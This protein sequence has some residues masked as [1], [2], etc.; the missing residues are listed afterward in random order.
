VD[1]R[2]ALFAVLVSV[3]AA[4]IFGLAPAVHAAR[5]NLNDTLKGMRTTGRVPS[6]LR[7]AFV[8]VQLSLALMLLFGAGLLARGFAR[9]LDWRPGF[10]RTNLATAWMSP[11]ANG[12]RNA[13]AEMER[14]RDEVAA[15]PGI[16][17]AALCSAGPLFGGEETGGLAIEGRPAFAPQDMPTVQ[18]F[19]VGPHYFETLGVR[20]LRGRGFSKS[21]AAGAPHVG[22]INQSLARRFFPGENP[23]GRQV[24]VNDHPS[25]IV[26]V[27]ADVRPLQ[28]D[29]PTP[30]QIYWPIQQYPRLGATLLLRVTPGATNVEKTVRDRIAAVNP[31][32]QLS[33]LT[34][35]DERLEKQ[36]VRPRFNVLLIAGFALIA[37][38]LAVVGVYG[39]IAHGV[40][41]RS[42]ELAVRVALGA[43]PRALVASVVGQGLRLAA[44]GIAAG[45]AGALAV[46][47]LLKSLLYGLPARDALTLAG[48]AA[49]LAIAAAAACWLP[50]RRASRVDPISALRAQ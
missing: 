46:G 34:S 9:L 18:W 10:D 33:A 25:E 41:S 26:G 13:V 40:A 6:R 17:S 39:V 37:V 8:V 22:I 27:V 29:R 35:I 16:R 5:A 45:C 3:V 19:D 47:Q 12:T 24:T 48:A 36:L 50:A 31:R 23:I 30:P 20:L 21:D 44:I 42:R 28:P 2:V 38:L 4:L 1:G 15:L 49:L 43:T 14:I 7:P 11:A 32:V